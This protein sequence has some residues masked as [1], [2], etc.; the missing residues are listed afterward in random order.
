MQ[1]Q[2]SQHEGHLI[3]IKNPKFDFLVRYVGWASLFLLATVLINNILSISFGFPE[4]LKLFSYGSNWLLQ[5]VLYLA[6][7][8]FTFVW[9]LKSQAKELRKEA[10]HISDFNMYLIRACF[11]AVF[12]TGI[13]DA[14][15]ASLR[16]ENVFSILFLDE[17]ASG[18]TKS[19]FMGLYVH[20]P[21]VIIAFIA[22][23][24]F[25]TLGFPWLA[26][27]IVLAELFI[28]VA[29]FL[30]SY[31]QPWMGDLVRYWYAS[32]FL[33]ASAFTLL[34]NEHVRVDV[35]YAGFSNKKKGAINA[36]GTILLG[37]TTCWTIIIIGFGHPL[38]I[39]NSP[40]LNFEISQAGVNGMFIKYQM[41]AFLGIFAITMLIQF[42]SYLFSAYADYRGYSSIDSVRFEEGK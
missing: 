30:F 1:E 12:L 38:A 24:F 37:M 35:L 25:R 22:A 28:V 27:L 2:N 17:F 3:V 16:V 32:L 6:V 23:L 10:K 33:L 36:I 39:I 4:I 15:I 29:R 8:F 11:F 42:V 41:A 26:L 9:V 34:E 31:E 13:V 14:S 18:L 40:V 5:I 7:L 19:R 20:I 21:L